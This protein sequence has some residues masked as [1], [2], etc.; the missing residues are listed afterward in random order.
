MYLFI[1]TEQEKRLIV[2][3]ETHKKLKL[4]ATKKG[5]TIKAELKEILEKEL[6]VDDINE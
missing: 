4:R 5:S 6:G 3:S 1:M 2:D